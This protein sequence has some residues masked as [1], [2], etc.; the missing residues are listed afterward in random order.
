[1][2][3]KMYA[4]YDEGCGNLSE[5][6]NTI[7]EAKDEA[8]YNI[9]NDNNGNIYVVEIKPIYKVKMAQVSFEKVV[10]KE[11]KKWKKERK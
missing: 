5:A 11:D 2:K 1:M 10:K 7:D 4:T 9:E 6:F 3:Q 8:K